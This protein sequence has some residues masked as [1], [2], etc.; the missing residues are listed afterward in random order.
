MSNRGIKL[1]FTDD[2]RKYVVLTIKPIKI[3]FRTDDTGIKHTETKVNTCF[4]FCNYNFFANI[5]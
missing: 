1:D 5:Y 2:A 3:G 4:F